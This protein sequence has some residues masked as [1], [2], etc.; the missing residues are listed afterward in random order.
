MREGTVMKLGYKMG[1][2][3]PTKAKL[4]KKWQLPNLEG[5]LVAKSKPFWPIGSG[6]TQALD[7]NNLH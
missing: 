3:E 5:D 6:A 2:S 7:L 1:V 4:L